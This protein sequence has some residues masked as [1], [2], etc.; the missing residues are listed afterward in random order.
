V[1]CLSYPRESSVQYDV[2]AGVQGTIEG[3]DPVC[4]NVH[5]PPNARQHYDLAGTDGAPMR[6]WW[7]FLFY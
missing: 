6:N 1:P 2:S 7:P 3:Y 4:G 5:W